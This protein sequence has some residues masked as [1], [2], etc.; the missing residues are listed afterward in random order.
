MSPIVRQV[1]RDAALDVAARWGGGRM[2][3]GRWLWLGPLMAIL[4]LAAA[5]DVGDAKGPLDLA[6]RTL[7]AAA[8]AALFLN[9]AVK[10]V[11]DLALGGWP[12]RWRCTAPWPP[13]G[14]RRRPSPCC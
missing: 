5:E 14:S 9:V 7:A 2:G 8:M 13:P 6:G 3:R 1:A 12:A 11:R 10:R 4:A